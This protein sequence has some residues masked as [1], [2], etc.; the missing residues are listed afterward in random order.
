MKILIVLL[1]VAVSIVYGSGQKGLLAQSFEVA[2]V[3][4]TGG[5]GG[6]GGFPQLNPNRLGV[7]NMTLYDLIA[8]AYL[9]DGKPNIFCCV[10]LSKSDLISRGPVL[11][12]RDLFPI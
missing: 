4:P 3:R 12:M 5:S 7:T 11:I 2:S 1:L 8:L 9:G 10:A 6:C